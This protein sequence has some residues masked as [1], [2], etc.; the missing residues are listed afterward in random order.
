MD[1]QLG[2]KLCQPQY[3]AWAPLKI[4]SCIAFCMHLCDQRL[5]CICDWKGRS[6][7]NSIEKLTWILWHNRLW[8][9]II[10]G[11]KKV[12]WQQYHR[13]GHFRCKNIIVV[14]VNHEN[15]KHKNYI[16][17]QIIS[18]F[19][20]QSHSIASSLFCL[21]FD[22][23]R[24]DSWQTHDNFLLTVRL[25]ACLYCHSTCLQRLPLLFCMCVVHQQLH[26]SHER[27]KLFVLHWHV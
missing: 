7:Y 6:V 1:S 23:C 4:F 14:H 21:I 17:L 2:A 3:Q 11:I 16:L 8:E 15:N 25:I 22:N 5:H 9:I 12:I 26:G 27:S 20:T 10:T 18:T 19:C 24:G 13:S